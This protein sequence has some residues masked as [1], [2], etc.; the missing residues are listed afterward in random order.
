MPEKNENYVKKVVLDLE[1]PTIVVPLRTS[2]FDN[3]DPLPTFLE[4]HA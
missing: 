3:I 1:L 4:P 2:S